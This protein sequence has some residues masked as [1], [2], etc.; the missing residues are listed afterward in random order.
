MTTNHKIVLLLLH[1]CNFP[2][3]MNYNVNI[4]YAG[5]LI[6]DPVEGSINPQVETRDNHYSELLR[7]FSALLEGPGSAPSMHMKAHKGL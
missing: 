4:L 6:H 3:V 2:R 7:A 1:K 5:Y